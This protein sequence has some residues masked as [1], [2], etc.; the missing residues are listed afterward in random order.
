[1]NRTGPQALADIAQRRIVDLPGRGRCP[2]WETSGPPATPALVLLHGATLNAE[3]NWSGVI[4]TLAPHYR[5]HF[6]PT[7]AR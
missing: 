3:L 1:M 4:A 6:R 2:V 7:R 5:I